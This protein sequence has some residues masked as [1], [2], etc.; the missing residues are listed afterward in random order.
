[1]EYI[2]EYFK[3]LIFT[4]VVEDKEGYAIYGAGIHC[5]IGGD[6]K[7]YVLA[8]VPVTFAKKRQS[9]LKDLMWKNL[10]TRNLKNSYNLKQ[11]RWSIPREVP[12]FLL[13]VSDRKKEYSVYNCDEIPFEIL[14]L[15]NPRKKTEYQYHNKLML[16][17][18][19]D[20]FETLINY[21]EPVVH[22]PFINPE[23]TNHYSQDHILRL[24]QHDDP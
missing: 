11:Q 14:L 20:M 5:N 24:Q 10:Q 4:K 22:Y 19:I 21:K 23:T 3:D 18:A 12:D 8:F 13:Y 1:M 6:K 2:N 15:H 9:L 16:S 17:A 7:R